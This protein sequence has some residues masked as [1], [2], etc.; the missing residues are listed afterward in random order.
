MECIPVP[1]DSIQL[2][3]THLMKT[4]YQNDTDRQRT[5]LYSLLPSKEKQIHRNIKL[6]NV[7]RRKIEEIRLAIIRHSQYSKEHAQDLW[8]DIR[9]LEKQIA[10]L[11]A[12]TPQLF[13]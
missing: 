5:L 13:I 1:D 6:I 9:D 4:Q 10:D 12:I 3:I 7:K 2:L 8:D 11:E